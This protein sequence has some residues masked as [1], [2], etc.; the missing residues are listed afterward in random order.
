[1]CLKMSTNLK[2][3]FF[4]SEWEE[5]HDMKWRLGLERSD[6]IFGFYIQ[7]DPIALTDK[8]LIETEIQFKMVGKNK[9]SYIKNWKENFKNKKG[10]RMLLLKRKEDEKVYVI[11][12]NLSV[13]V[14][15]CIIKTNKFGVEPNRLFDESQKDLSD[16]VLVVGDVKFFVLRKFL[17]GQSPVFKALLLGKFS[18]SEMSEIPLAG[19]DPHDFQYYLEVL[20]GE[21]AIDDSTVEGILHVAD[22]YETSSVT[23]KCE[24]FL[25]EKSKKSSEDMRELAAQY[26]LM[27]LKEKVHE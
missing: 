13:E 1:M 26:N 20:H 22:M 12:G 4:Y 17:A 15:V 24:E 14:T 6:A 18:E 23:R 25:L 7:C 5:F 9:N 11:D 8:W 2:K 16:V 21:S 19:I 27:T 10:R 3:K